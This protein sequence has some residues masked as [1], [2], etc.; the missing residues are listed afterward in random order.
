LRDRFF[1]ANLRERLVL[2][3][4]EPLAHLLC[5]SLDRGRRG[6]EQGA[7]G[8]ECLGFLG[9]AQGDGIRGG[10]THL[11]RGKLAL[12]APGGVERNV[13][14]AAGVWL[15]NATHELDHPPGVRN[16]FSLSSLCVVGA[17]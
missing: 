7:L 8:K 6:L 16:S 11:D 12:H 14:F 4:F 15:I 13:A 2:M 10:V 5:H 9:R 17:W 1:R 3:V